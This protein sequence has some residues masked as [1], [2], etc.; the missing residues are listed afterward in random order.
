MSEQI[1]L[2][3]SVEKQVGSVKNIDFGFSKVETVDGNYVI[4]TILE[5][6]STDQEFD[7]FTSALIDDVK[8][9]V[10]QSDQPLSVKLDDT[11]NT[12]IAVADLMLL[13]ASPTKLYISVPG[14]TD[15]NAKIIYGGIQT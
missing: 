14:G 13:T 10:I 2:A 5:A 1:T 8:F 15:A 4:E 11:G 6:G 3:V 7:L 9:V 12:A